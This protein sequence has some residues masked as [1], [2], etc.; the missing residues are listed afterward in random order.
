M[1]PLG[2]SFTPARSDPFCRSIILVT[3]KTYPAASPGK[4]KWSKVTISPLTIDQMHHIYVVEI[5]QDVNEAMRWCM[6]EARDGA[7]EGQGRLSGRKKKCYDTC[8]TGAPTTLS[9]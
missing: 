8:L 1:D 9:W 4:L 6:G 7:E 3:G 2:G 5:F